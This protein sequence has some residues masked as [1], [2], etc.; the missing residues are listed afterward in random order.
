MYTC[1]HVH[2]HM[3]LYMAVMYEDT[4]GREPTVHALEWMDTHHHFMWSPS[5]LTAPPSVFSFFKSFFPI[6]RMKKNSFG[7][8][9]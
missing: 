8:S 5:S 1:A 2:T 6:I 3:H 9:V 4:Q 7:G